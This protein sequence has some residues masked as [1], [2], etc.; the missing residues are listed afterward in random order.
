V[1]FVTVWGWGEDCITTWGWGCPAGDEFEIRHDDLVEVVDEFDSLKI[2]LGVT[3]LACA[4]TGSAES[5]FAGHAV[6][7]YGGWDALS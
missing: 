3:D 5:V 2:H 1:A 7:D 4:F 6:H